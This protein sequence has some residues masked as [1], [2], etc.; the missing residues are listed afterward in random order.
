MIACFIDNNQYQVPFHI[1][2]AYELIRVLFS[3][4]FQSKYIYFS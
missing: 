2:S 4:L 3:E 1:E